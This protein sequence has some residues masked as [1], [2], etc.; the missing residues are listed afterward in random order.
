MTIVCSCGSTTS[1]IY[2]SIHTIE[3]IIKQY[4]N[5]AIPPYADDDHANNASSSSRSSSND[6][7]IDSSC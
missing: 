5:V 1:I 2:V 7:A 6:M 3:D 4:L